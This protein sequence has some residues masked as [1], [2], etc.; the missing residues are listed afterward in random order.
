MNNAARHSTQENKAR[1]V[2]KARRA[3]HCIRA[4]SIGRDAIGEGGREGGFGRL[5]KKVECV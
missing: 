3:G 2:K 5:K 1:R 4:L